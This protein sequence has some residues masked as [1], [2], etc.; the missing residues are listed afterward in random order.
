MF[1]NF[2]IDSRS[3]G[4]KPLIADHFPLI[5]LRFIVIIP[6]NHN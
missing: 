3:I 4:Y 6:V 5:P 2:L 1:N